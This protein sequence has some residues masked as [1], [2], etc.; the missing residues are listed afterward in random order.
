MSQ[1]EIG[2]FFT[3]ETFGF[4]SDLEKNNSR[5]WFNANK[6][7]YEEFVKEPFL[8]F[9]TAAGPQLRKISPNIVADPRP[10][11]GSFF[12]IYRDVRFSADKSPY[13]TN[14]GAYFRHSSG[15]E[16]P[17]PGY[18]LHVSPEMSFL[19]GGMYMPDSKALLKVREEIVARPSE[20]KALRKKI[21]LSEEEALKR[22]PKGFDPNHPLIDDL[23]QKHF[24]S[25]VIYSRGQVCSPKF[26]AEFVKGCKSLVPLMKFLSSAMGVAW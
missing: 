23:K 15:K 8:E 10:S 21:D 17:A 18:Y 25:S 22:A 6:R 3:K 4:L 19:A 7:R 12:R 24:V 11:G 2:G 9:I 1:T 26:M 16:S 14:A 20:W 13:K 5:E